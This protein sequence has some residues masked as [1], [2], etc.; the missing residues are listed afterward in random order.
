[1]SVSVVDMTGVPHIKA[2]LWVGDEPRDIV[3]AGKDRQRAFI[4]AAYRGQNHP[5]FKSQHLRENGHG[6]A[7][8]WV[9]DRNALGASAGGDPVTIV[10]LFSDAPRAL[11]VSNDGA[12]VYAAAFMSGNRTTVIEEDALKAEL[13]PILLGYY[14]RIGG[15]DLTISQL[16]AITGYSAGNLG[17]SDQALIDYGLQLGI[18]ARINGELVVP[19][20]NSKIYRINQQGQVVNQVSHEVLSESMPS[21]VALVAAADVAPYTAPRSKPAPTV[22]A[23][24]QAAPDTGLI[25]KF[26]GQAWRDESGTDWSDKV[27]FS[28]PDYDVFAL[29][30]MAD[31]PEEKSRIAQV[32]TTLFNLA[33]NPVSGTLYV[34]NLDARNDVRFEGPGLNAST[35]RG[36]IAQSRISIIENGTVSARNLNKHLTHTEA[37]GES[38]AASEKAKTLSQPL[39]MEVTADG[40]TLYVAALGSNKVGVFK[41]QSLEQDSFTPDANESISL[42]ASGPTG[43]VLNAGGNRLFV[44]SRFDNSIR[45]LDTT[46][47]QVLATRAMF[48]PEPK[49]VVDGRRFLYDA[50]LTSA[51]GENACASCHVFGDL[52]ALSWDLGNP[53]DTMQAKPVNHD[54]PALSPSQAPFHPMK[55]PMST[56]TLRGIAD[57]G[58]MHWRGDRT[59]DDPAI[60]KGQLESREAAAFKAFNPAFVTLV[61]RAQALDET[62]MQQFTDFALQIMPPPNPIRALDNSLS[63]EQEQGHTIYMNGGTTAVGTCNACHEV[64]DNKNHFGSNTLLTN[65]G[66]R[67]SQDFKVP[68]LRNAYAKV[69]RFDDGVEQ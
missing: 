57:H 27:N 35:V 54:T 40:K 3:F 17:M 36:H 13:D 21:G 22:N 41:T 42:P 44:A 12:T 59:G 33:V 6:R 67:V 25:V 47:K 64:N 49:S 52:D 23:D 66:G 1:D 32:G 16:E 43:L 61:G 56:Q 28:L 10:N 38:I 53:D 4:T 34:S 50:D 62:Q 29:D 18:L 15:G 5:S 60:V 39:Q 65:E 19:Y 51:N 37:Q 69:G 30:A 55:G 68:Q 58:P 31:I 46:T 63:A 9:F 48:S 20:H 2:T 24:G 8:V 45:V 26:D 11:A 7:D 14:H